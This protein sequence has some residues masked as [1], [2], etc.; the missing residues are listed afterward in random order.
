MEKLLQVFSA[1]KTDALK[2]KDDCLRLKD[3]ET[4]RAA[5]VFR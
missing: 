5:M 3:P 4:K 2:I 1:M